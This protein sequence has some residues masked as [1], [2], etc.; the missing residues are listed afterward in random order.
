MISLTFTACHRG[1]SNANGSTPVVSRQ[2]ETSLPM[3]PL[4]SDAEIGWTIASARH[5]KLADY[6]DKVIVLD[7]YATWCEPCRESTPHLVELQNRYGGKGLQIVGLNVGGE[8]DYDKVMSFAREFHV[9][10][11]LGIPDSELED[12]YMGGNTAIPQTFVL[13]RQG[14]LVRHF[15][16][17]DSSMDQELDQAIQASLAAKPTTQSGQ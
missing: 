4:K 13:D 10:Y 9:P 16:G 15:E 12:L 17:Y 14:K 7:F 1:S 11:Q 2:P 3:P 8:E 6:R 5:L